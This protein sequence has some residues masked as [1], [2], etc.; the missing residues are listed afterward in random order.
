MQTLDHVPAEARRRIAQE[1]LEIYGPLAHRL[2][3]SRVK[4]ELEDLA[5]YFLYPH[6][7]AELESR[8]QGE[9]QA[10][11]GVDPQDQRAPRRRARARRPRGRDQLA[12]Q[13]LLL[14]LPEAAAARHRAP[15]ALRLPGVP[16][17]HRHRARRL[18]RARRD[19]PDLASDPGPVQGLHRGVEAEPLPVAPHHRGV[20]RGA[21][22]RGA[23]PHPRDG[24]DRGRG[25]RR[26]LALQGGQ[27]H[28]RRQRLQHPL[29]APAARVAAR[30]AGA[31]RVPREPQARPLSRGRLRLHPQGR[32]L[33]VPA[34]RHLARLRLPHPHRPRPPLHRGSHQRQARAA[35][36][37]AA[38]R[39]HRRDPDQSG[40]A[41]QPRLAEHGQ[42]LAR[43]LEDP[44]VAPHP[45]EAAGRGDRA[46]AARAGAQEGA[47][48]SPRRRCARPR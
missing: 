45:A 29:A 40:R 19:P 7:F 48:A 22:V 2:G 26:A 44:P 17:R 12:G 28:L 37:R 34:R 43:A 42:D 30:G 39:R 8:A 46:P 14:D 1:T 21:A 25:H 47:A 24:R 3:M 20:G 35:A 15:A 9:G 11:R 32:R 31:A 27:D 38:Q 18:R 33:L 10:G 5:F 13:G 36:D 41:S 6:Q 23:D 4:T 16:H